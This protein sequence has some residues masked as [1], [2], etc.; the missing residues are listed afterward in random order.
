[1]DTWLYF[2]IGLSSQLYPVMLRRVAYVLT[3]VCILAAIFRMRLERDREAVLY[4]LAYVAFPVLTVWLL[5]QAK[6]MYSIRYLLLF[7]PPYCILV[8]KGID[9]LRWSGA[10]IAVALFLVLTLLVGNWNTWR[11]EQNADWRGVASHVLGQAQPGD[12]AL[13]SPR[14][15]E[16]P[17]DYYNRGRIDINMDLPIPVTVDAAQRVVADISRRHQRVWLVWQSGHYSDPDGVV[18]QILESRYQVVQERG[19]RGVDRLIL[20]DLNA[21]VG[22]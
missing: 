2:S 18:K 1:V 4:C 11:T 10:R 6:P 8:A 19:F 12:V 14:W 9:S 15:N 22:N 13:F 17:F 7:L 16:K 5:S 20:Y 21:E 3:A